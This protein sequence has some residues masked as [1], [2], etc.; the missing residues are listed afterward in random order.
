MQR[1]TSRLRTR[2]E[3]AGLAREKLAALAECSTTTLRNVEAG[4]R[5]SPATARQI[6]AALHC[7]PR[8]IFEWLSEDA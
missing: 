4:M 5:C 8:E 2:R 1:T 3:G 6:A 7:E